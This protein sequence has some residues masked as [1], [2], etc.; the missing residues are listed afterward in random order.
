MTVRLLE[1]VR[2]VELALL[3]AGGVGTV[4]ADLGADVVKIERPG[5]GDYIRAT[6]WPFVH[7]VS[8]MHHHL[9]RGKR[10]VGIDI[11]RP[12]GA[13]LAARVMTGA[14]V[15]VEGMR[16]GA[17]ARRG[18]DAATLRPRAP[19]LVW[20]TVS[21]YGTT[22]PYAQLAAHGV[23]FDAWAGGVRVETTD[24]GFTTGVLGPTLG[25]RVAP[26]LATSAILAAVLRARSTGQG[27]TIDIAQC[28]AAAAV[29]WLTIES[30]R[31]YRRPEPEVTGNPAD[32]GARRAPGT[33]G[34]RDSVRY[35]VY[36][37]A[38]GHVLLM[39]TERKFWAQFCAAV[40]RPDLVGEQTGRYA[41]HALGDVRL[42]K[43]LTDLFA[44]RTTAEWVHLGLSADVPI[45]PVNR[46][47][48]LPDDP[49]FAA[50]TG[51]LPADRYG[52]DLLPLPVRLVD[53][54]LAAPAP[55]ATPGQHTDEVLAELG[56]DE[57]ERD[58]LRSTGALG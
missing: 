26:L 49:H 29:D 58:R 39:A 31:A 27:A 43:E 25:T 44:T 9:G 1:G 10:S 11:Q 13:A 52:A 38:D 20:C 57:A 32:G 12:E 48:T 17:L 35:Q 30:H 42:R 46:P 14:D 36:R 50:R 56:L 7:G 34:M 53:E 24:E 23:A 33:A 22:G 16:P 3:E 28:E 47:D 18:L 19:Q 45:A 4:L 40:D 2:V 41:N 15:V 54:E 51:W 55:A 6:G 8:L 37:S 5:T 21:G